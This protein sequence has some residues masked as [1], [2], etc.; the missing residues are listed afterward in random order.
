[1]T[2]TEIVI[3]ASILLHQCNDSK[4]WINWNFWLEIWLIPSYSSIAVNICGSAEVRHHAEEVQDDRPID[5]RCSGQRLLRSHYFGCKVKYRKIVWR[6]RQLQS[7]HCLPN[8]VLVGCVR[9]AQVQKH[10]HLPQQVL[11][12]GTL[13]I[14]FGI[15]NVKYFYN[16]QVNQKK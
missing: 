12:I 16:H 4:K 13:E 10:V 1:M 11:T 7:F 2:A 5:T 8:L 9:S 15:F 3:I 6:W 14:E